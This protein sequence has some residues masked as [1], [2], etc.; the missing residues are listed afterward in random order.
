M[1]K[2]GFL[3]VSPRSTLEDMFRFLSP[4]ALPLRFSKA[5]VAC[6]KL[7]EISSPL[8]LVLISASSA[9]E[10]EFKLLHQARLDLEEVLLSHVSPHQDRIIIEMGYRKDLVEQSIYRPQQ[11]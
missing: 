2:I 11:V 5:Y 10:N 8:S 1:T 7:E 6:L 9:S 3:F 4:L